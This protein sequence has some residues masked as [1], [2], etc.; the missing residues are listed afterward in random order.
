[1]RNNGTWIPR[2]ESAFIQKRIRGFHSATKMKSSLNH[3]FAMAIWSRKLDH[4]YVYYIYTYIS[5]CV[6]PPHGLV[7]HGYSKE[8]E[9]QNIEDLPA[10]SCP[11]LINTL[12]NSHVH[13]LFASQGE[14]HN[15][16]HGSLCRVRYIKNNLSSLGVIIWYMEVSRN[17][18]TPKIIYL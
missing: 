1:M 9:T 17:R 18:G 4:I 16:L 10:I 8:I 5:V 13:S 12:V 11:T 6:D 15:T 7:H 3:R 2:V 14:R